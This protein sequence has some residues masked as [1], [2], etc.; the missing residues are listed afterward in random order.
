[1]QL[2]KNLL[3]YFSDQPLWRML[4]QIVNTKSCIQP[5]F[6]LE[7]LKIILTKYHMYPNER[8]SENELFANL[9]ENFKSELN[10]TC[11]STLFA[12]SVFL[13]SDHPSRTT[14][15]PILLLCKYNPSKWTLSRIEN[16]L[17]PLI[18][19]KSNSKLMRSVITL[20]AR[21]ASQFDAET[22]VDLFENL[23]SWS[24]RSMSGKENP[25]FYILQLI[26]FPLQILHNNWIVWKLV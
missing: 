16:D 6:S 8:W 1:M 25:C 9:L 13:I 4:V 15:L 7:N 12:N 17:K 18:E 3:T 22:D 10:R 26:I 23:K 14:E 11:V 19:D 20:I 5:G 2:I 21:L 24:D